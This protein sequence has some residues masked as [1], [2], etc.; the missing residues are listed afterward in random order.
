MRLQ[1]GVTLDPSNGQA[2]VVLRVYWAAVLGG[3]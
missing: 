3:G 2:G 1:I